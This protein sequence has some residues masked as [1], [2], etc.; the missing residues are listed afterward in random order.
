MWLRSAGSNL[1]WNYNSVCLCKPLIWEILLARILCLIRLQS[2]LII[3]ISG[4]KSIS[5]FNCM[6]YLRFTCRY[7]ARKETTKHLRLDL[8]LIRCIHKC[9]FASQF[10]G[11]LRVFL[12]VLGFPN[13][14]KW[15]F[16]NVM[17]KF[18]MIYWNV[19][20]S[21]QIVEF[22]DHQCQ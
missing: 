16:H 14:L 5:F 22:F 8:F 12:V 18:Q 9:P 7:S 21:N 6:L 4:R 13:R 15:F 10:L 11:L 19:L 20:S 2:F 3:S 1:K 17:H